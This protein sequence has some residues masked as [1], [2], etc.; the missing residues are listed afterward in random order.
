[1][2]D[3][4]ALIKQA[5]QKLAEAGCVSPQNDAELLLAF[6]LDIERSQLVAVESITSDQ[7]NKYS[8]LLS[9]RAQRIPLQHLTGYAYFRYL[10]LQ[11]G[12]GVFI[13]RP[14]TE[15]LV[16]AGLDELAKLDGPKLAV[17]LCAGSGAV[18]LSLALESPDT[19]VHAV[20]LSPE[21]FNWFEKNLHSYSEQLA[22]LNSSVI[23][24]NDD[25]T[26]RELLNQFLG[27]ADVVL[28]NP[29]YIPD[30]MIPREPE[31]RDFDPDMALYGGEDGLDVARK[32]SLVAA[33]L[34][35]P[36]G[37]FAMEH[38][39]VQ[40]ES[41]VEML[42]ML[43]NDGQPLWHN[44]NDNLDYNQLPRFVSAYRTSFS[45]HGSV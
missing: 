2:S 10:S 13:P 9:K 11:V 23:P 6:V 24:H 41:V 17:D 5:T 31:V 1:M 20:E 26:S 4:R 7:A 29:P 21:A 27:A 36:G 38:A 40:S 32:V 25:A 39:D 16:Q 30:A 22:R 18:A 3:V 33:D 12:S 14:E 37:F 44:I 35:K 42:T 15:L 43:T 28:S 34:L 45:S 8:E 19:T